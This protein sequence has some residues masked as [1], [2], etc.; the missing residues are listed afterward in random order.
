M[1]QASSS[2]FSSV[3]APNSRSVTW[4]LE[5]RKVCVCET[6][7]CS[8]YEE[9]KGGGKREG[10]RTIT[11]ENVASFLGRPRVFCVFPGI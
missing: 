6:P 10:D 3:L 7:F 9:W 1:A 2:H 5:G 8:L 11:S 4:R